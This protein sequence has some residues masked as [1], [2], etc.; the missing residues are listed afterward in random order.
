MYW[1]SQAALRSG[2]IPAAPLLPVRSGY[3]SSQN[4]N[5]V[6]AIFCT[7]MAAAISPCSRAS[8]GS[9][10]ADTRKWTCSR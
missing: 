2:R 8:I 6:R 10:C 9:I 5:R 1:K 4:R 7:P 3:S